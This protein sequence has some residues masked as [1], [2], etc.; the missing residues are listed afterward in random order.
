MK[1]E[2]LERLANIAEAHEQIQALISMARPIF[3]T[4]ARKRM[5]YMLATGGNCDGMTV[6]LMV[7]DHRRAYDAG[8]TRLAG[9]DIIWCQRGRSLGRTWLRH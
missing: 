2:T 5:R 7:E 6:T 8:I 9:I 3:P 4:L 1:P